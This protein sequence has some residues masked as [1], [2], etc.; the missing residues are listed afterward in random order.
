MR[1]KN[2]PYMC[3]I[4]IYM[5][6]I[7]TLYTHTCAIY[8]IHAL[9]TY[10]HIH[11]LYT[12]TCAISMRHTC[13]IYIYTCVLYI[14]YIHTHVIYTI[15]MRYIHAPYMRCIPDARVMLLCLMQD[16]LLSRDM[17]RNTRQ[18]TTHTATHCNTLQHNAT[19]CNRLQ[20]TATD[21]DTP[22]HKT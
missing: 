16:H 6:S 4:H 10:I 14:H 1:C 9:Y 3:Y 20:Q 12:Y 2:A 11:T 19:Q 8:Y 5:R 7:H 15:Y 21:S 17:L 13:A 18:Q 22:Q